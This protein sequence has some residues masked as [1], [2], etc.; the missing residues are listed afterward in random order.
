MAARNICVGVEN[1]FHKCC[2]WTPL[3][4]THQ[5]SL[6][7]SINSMSTGHGHPGT[8]AQPAAK[9]ELS[10]NPPGGQAIAAARV[11]FTAGAASTPPAGAEAGSILDNTGKRA[12]IVEEHRSSVESNVK[13]PARLD[14]LLSCVP[15]RGALLRWYQSQPRSVQ[16]S[17]RVLASW[18]TCWTVHLGSDKLFQLLGYNFRAE[19]GHHAAVHISNRVVSSLNG[20]VSGSL[21][22]Y[23]VLIKRAFE[24]DTVSVYPREMDTLWSWLLGYQLYDLLAEYIGGHTPQSI[25]I[26]HSMA[27]LACVV[28]LTHRHCCFYPVSF[29]CTEFTVIPANAYFWMKTL[30]LDQRYPRLFR[31]VEFARML[32][33]WIM[34]LFCGPLA[35]YHGWRLGDLPRLWSERKHWIVPFSLV[36]AVPLVSVLNVHWTILMTRSFF[37]PKQ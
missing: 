23:M 10:S 3:Y 30:L 24:R 31:S 15:Y 28:A 5:R 17:L 1:G 14:A 35:L 7:G 26:H 8:D 36:L 25:W 2:S 4:Y 21:A 20:I 12:E 11:Q 34:R 29:T 33:Y 19:L 16:L 27:V 13:S 18:L 32:S 6:Q 9:R 37:Y 22:V